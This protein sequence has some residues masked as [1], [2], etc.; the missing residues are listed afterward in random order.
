MLMRGRNI[1]CKT[2]RLS[3]QGDIEL[4][5]GGFYSVVYAICQSR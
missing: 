4:I 1:L 3:T 2:E 5:E